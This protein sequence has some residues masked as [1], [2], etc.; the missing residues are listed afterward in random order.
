MTLEMT[1]THGP[2]DE[3]C[4]K[5]LEQLWGF[6]LPKDYRRFLLKYNGGRS[7]KSYFNFPDIPEGGSVVH[8]FFG[9]YKS[10]NDNLLQRIIDI[11]DRYPSDSFPIADDVFGNRICLI[12]KGRN[13]GQVY[14]WDHEM[15]THEGEDPNYDNMTLIAESFTEFIENLYE[16]RD[17]SE[18]DK[19]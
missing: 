10:E 7:E 12:V 8:T 4:L 14:F 15:E 16:G 9:I 5:A 17:K 13:R 3:N 11:G 6:Q 19:P 2:L 1:N 18:S